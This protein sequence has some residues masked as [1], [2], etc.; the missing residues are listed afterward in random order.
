VEKI[1]ELINGCLKNNR[2][3]QGE[4]YQIFAPKMYAVCLRYTSSQFDAQDILQD[5]FLK[6]FE[7]L[8]SYKGSGSL[9]GWMKRIFI[10][11]AL[12]KYR[13]RISHLSVHDMNDSEDLGDS[14]A[15]AIDNLS[16]KEI[17]AYIRELPDQYRMVFNL[18]V[19]EGL[20]H[21]EISKIMNIGESTSRSN[22]AR[23]KTI[24]KEKIEYRTKWIEKAI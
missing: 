13:S 24:L 3:K 23:A 10:H 5:G 19:L 9:E 22:L 6:I 12:D 20:T 21:Q 16:E 1:N 18:Y 11:L 4:F 14:E 2:R 7:N 17:L 8:K 15:S